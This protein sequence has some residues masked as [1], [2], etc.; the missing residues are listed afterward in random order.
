MVLNARVARMGAAAASALLCWLCVPPC[1]FWPAVLVCWS[2][3]IAVVANA[4]WRRA[5]GLGLLHGILVNLGAFYWIY[6]SLRGVA[7][8][9]A[10]QAAPLFAL[11]VVVQASRSVLAA[12]L[13]AAGTGRGWPVLLVFPASLVASELVCPVPFPWHTAL[14]TQSVP[15]WMQLADVGGPLL[16]SAWVGIVSAGFAEAWLCRQRGTRSALQALAPSLLVLGLVTG[17]GKWRIAAIDAWVARA[18]TARLGVVQ[19][20]LGPRGDG[21]RDPAA[22][23]RKLSLELLEREPRLDLLVWPETAISYPTRSERLPEFFRNGIF[24]DRRQAVSTKRIDVPLV[25]GMVVSRKG[26]QGGAELTNS[27]V[28]AD[29]SG[30]MLGVYD[31][32]ALVPLGERA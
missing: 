32:Q 29:E 24:R 27:A 10:W 21:R 5:V 18:A 16:L 15:A 13:T 26:Q 31:K 28:L 7:E 19:G 14:F 2:P 12:L 3:L 8:L 9:P 17:V 23:Y 1:D 25:A 11:L 30:R 20:N 4:P 22:A 6:P